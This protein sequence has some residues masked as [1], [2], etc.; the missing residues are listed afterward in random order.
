ML[1][2]VLSPTA[3]GSSRSSVSTRE[4]RLE[5]TEIRRRLG[6][7]P[8]DPGFYRGLLGVRSRRLR[9]RA[10]GDVRSVGARPTRCGACSTR[11]TSPMSCTRRSGPCRVAMRQRVALAAALLGRPDCSCSTSRRPGLDPGAATAAAFV[12][13]RARTAGTVVLSTHHTVEVAAFCHRV[14]VM[15]RGR[16][17]FDGTPAELAQLAAGRV[18]VDHD[19]PVPIGTG[20]GRG[21]R[22]TAHPRDRLT[23][24]RRR[25][26][27]A[28]D[29]RRLPAAHARGGRAMIA[30]MP[31]VASR[32][33]GHPTVALAVVEARRCVRSVWLWVGVALPRGS[34]SRRV[35]VP[36]RRTRTNG[37]SR[38]RCR[39]PWRSS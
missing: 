7:L 26:G 5:R 17:Q 37:C 29:R 12:A 10:E 25:A 24:R 21:S 20:S 34:W 35:M 14:V 15:L 4:E 33:G 6:Y 16:V 31:T 8:Q 9:R 27:R 39:S 32:G 2:T 1:A 28:H 23:A 3:G 11:S 18:W 19:A 22:P 36:G 38:R 13:L 30:T